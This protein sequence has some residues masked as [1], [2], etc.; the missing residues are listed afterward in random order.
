MASA[1]LQESRSDAKRWTGKGLHSL[2]SL[3]DRPSVS[4]HL[5]LAHST[6]KNRRATCRSHEQRHR[7]RSVSPSPHACL[8]VVENST[9]PRLSSWRQ[10][11]SSWP[12]AWCQSF[13]TA[14][15][16]T[17][18]TGVAEPTDGGGGGDDDDDDE[19]RTP[20]AV[21]PRMRT[22]M[23]W[24]RTRAMVTIKIPRR[25]GCWFRRPRTSWS[26]GQLSQDMHVIQCHHSHWCTVNHRG[27]CFFPALST[28]PC[29]VDPEPRCISLLRA[30]RRRRDDSTEELPPLPLFLPLPND[31]RSDS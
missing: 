31:R 14:V 28:I 19:L 18:A 17:R 4:C 16:T 30:T 15:G 27:S 8:V 5:V 7:P 1:S 12:T 25:R 3:R 13:A 11:C 21:L 2:L 6:E 23:M 10:N 26:L 24:L 29:G 20:A 9:G 22:R